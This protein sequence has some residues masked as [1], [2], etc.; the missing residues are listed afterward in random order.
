MRTRQLTPVAVGGLIAL[1]ALI[2][3]HTASGEPLATLYDTDGITWTT[4]GEYSQI[5][6][7][8]PRFGLMAA[9]GYA[10]STPDISVDFDFFHAEV[11]PTPVA[12]AFEDDF[13]DDPNASG[14]WTVYRYSDDPDREASWD[15]FGKAVYLTRAVNWKGVA[16]YANYNLIA[17][18]WR[19]DFRYKAGGGSGADGF[20]FFFY[21]D[22]RPQKPSAGGNLG[23][24]STL[25]NS[26]YA[27]EFDNWAGTN[28]PS[29]NHIALVDKSVFTHVKYAN[30][31][32]TED[33]NWHQVSV[34][35]DE[36][37]VSVTVDGSLLFEHTITAVDYTFSGIGFSASTG[38]W[39][40][41]HSIDDFVLR[42][43]Q[44][45]ETPFFWQ[46]DP[47]WADHPLRSNGQ[48]SS[49]YDTIGEGGCTL[50]SAAMVFRH[51]GARFSTFVPMDPPNLSDCMGTSACYFNW[52]AGSACTND[53]AS[54]PRVYA[55]TWSRL[56]Q[57]INQNHRPV[58]LGMYLKG[59]TDKTH[60][61]VVTR[62]QGSDPAN[63]YMYDP[64]YKCGQ[65]MKLS[66]YSGRYDF[67]WIVVYQGEATCSFS[68]A[69][70]QC[71]RSA[72]PVPVP[73]TAA[74]DTGWFRPPAQGDLT[75]RENPTNPLA[76]SGS[77]LLYRATE[78]TMTVELSAT[79]TIGNV[80]EML[81]WS[82]ALANSTWQ[83]YSPLAWLPLS[84]SVYVRFRNQFGDVSGTFSDTTIPAAPIAMP[85]PERAYL[86][87]I[88]K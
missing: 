30:D 22:N 81:I 21:K 73:V 86:P 59:N 53:K 2:V 48:C 79:A 60:W 85:D 9:N 33:N 58:I 19:A 66:H 11:G 76:L 23:F 34:Q 61:V 57:E 43:G 15:M 35:F 49:D 41:N 26:G 38:N 68:S 46:R 16:M 36:G 29:A 42:T 5:S 52:T 14:K 88:R 55:F 69:P 40:N 4:L 67:D 10:T 13:S 87:L 50:T 74:S 77:I 44:S 63:Y 80:T 70:P 31:S 18:S 47:L 56:D 12:A 75:L 84:D 64:W 32:R 37:H 78:I 20:T 71:E 27:I 28:D 6:F 39:N 3:S 83:A 24:H 54:I 51:L 7:A 25:P 45:C 17:K 82:D 72:A 1:F 8:S 62:G 65:N